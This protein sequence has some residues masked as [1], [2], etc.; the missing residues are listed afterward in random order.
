MRESISRRR[1]IDEEG[2][3][4]KMP[5]KARKQYQK[6]ILG[7]MLLLLVIM[8]YVALREYDTTFSAVSNDAGYLEKQQIVDGCTVL[9]V[10]MEQ[11][12]LYPQTYELTI[13]A[14]TESDSVSFQVLDRWTH[15]LLAEHV[16]TPGEEYHTVRFATD[17]IHRDVIVRSVYDGTMSDAGDSSEPVETSGATEQESILKI[18][19]Y[20]MRSD[21]KVGCDAKWDL[22]LFVLFLALVFF[23][24]WRF[25]SKGRGAVLF[26]STLSFCVSLPFFSE[27]LPMGHDIRFHISRILSIAYAIQERQIPQRLTYTLGGSEIVP[28]MYPEI[29]LYGAGAMVAAGATVFLAFKVTCIF[30]TFLT[31]FLAYYAARCVSSEKAAL[32]F[33]AVYVLNPYRMNELFLRAAIGE[34]LGMAFLPL[35]AVG[36]WQFF[37][38]EE[39]QGIKFLFLGYTGLLSSHIVLTVISAFFCLL[40][41]AAE[42]IAHP[43]EIRKRLR[44]FRKLLLLGGMLA[45]VNAWFLLPFL[46]FLGWE[47]AIS[48]STSS[49]WI[50][51]TS[52]YVWQV[53]MGGS[54]YGDN[55]ID[56]SAKDEMSVTIGPAMLMAMILFA[57]MYIKDRRK[58]AQNTVPTLTEKERSHGRWCLLF[59]TIALYLSSPYFP[60]TYLNENVSIWARTMGS[61]QYSWR[62]L[63]YAS[64]FL[65]FL[66]VVVVCALLHTK[67]LGKSL[68]AAGVVL[69]VFLSGFETATYYFSNPDYMC[70]RYDNELTTTY[71]YVIAE[72]AKNHGNEIRTWIESGE[73][74]KSTEEKSSLRIVD[75]RREGVNYRFSYEKEAGEEIQVTI[76]VFWYGLHRAYWTNGI[77]S[78]LAGKAEEITASMNEENQ[79]TA[80]TLPAESTAGEIVL[81]YEE[82]LLFRIG[83]WISI[84]GVAA[85]VLAAAGR[86]LGLPVKRKAQ[87]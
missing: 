83:N 29:L 64:L 61:I 69:L 28:I 9:A 31:A 78:A 51:G 33:A 32:L 85:L 54:L 79:F 44:G 65:S 25:F 11:V 86:R 76:P 75:Y 21:G 3:A 8:S 59:G 87:G 37:H 16:Y 67:A 41:I 38:E 20:T 23:G 66:L 58:A 26:L 45:A 1:T 35:V 56:Y 36:M 68:L 84:V 6:C 50:Q 22:Y 72:V 2:E 70:D 71:D 47:S 57:F 52:P 48:A 49:D 27:Y 80:V 53:F 17:R 40:Y 19:G 60:W 81:R 74:P 24:V 12:I 63:T 10:G 39:G 62:I 5:V 73:G 18:Y 15:T 7:A 4:E 77:G 13:D 30:I 34:A 14:K 55:K 43:W 82:P 42:F 46:S